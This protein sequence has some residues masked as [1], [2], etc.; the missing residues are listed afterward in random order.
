MVS[1]VL[2]HWLLLAIHRPDATFVTSKSSDISVGWSTVKMITMTL[3]SGLFI[4]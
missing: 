3:G 4:V 1:V 2:D